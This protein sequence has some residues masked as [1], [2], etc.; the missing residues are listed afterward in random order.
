MGD[1]KL[2]I[3]LTL[4]A[5]LAVG[6]A[7]A[8]GAPFDDERPVDAIGEMLSIPETTGSVD[9]EPHRLPLEGVRPAE[10]VPPATARRPAPKPAR[11]APVAEAYPVDLLIALA[12]DAVYSDAPYPKGQHADPR[13]IKLQVLLDRAH[14]SPGVIDGINGGNVA[15]AIAAFEMMIGHPVDGVMDAEL[16]ARLESV[17]SEPVLVSYEL[18]EKDVA[19]P[20]TPVLPADYAEQA[21]L[22]AA[23]YRDPVEML[24]ERF[25]MDEGFLRRLNPDVD[26]TM[27][28]SVITVANPG[29]PQKAK[30]A[31]IV[32]DKGRR[33]IFAYDLA[34]RLVA[35]YPATIG[36]ADLPSPTGVHAVKAI[37]INPEYWYRPKVNF[38]QGENTKALRLPPGPNAPVGSVW[39]GLDKPTYGLHGTPEPSK[40]DKTN[41]HGCVRLTNWDANEL[42]HLVAPGVPVDFREPELPQTAET[43]P[44]TTGI[45]PAR[46]VPY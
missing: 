30:V 31:S 5:A 42:A 25:H 28:G 2:A 17:S 15:K 44:L 40:I 12:N 3:A 33:Q 11:P 10:P 24:A 16:W 13:M 6:E 26:F 1:G 21:Q 38:Q 19:G 34:G 39:I 37:A 43:E 27:A 7:A 20:F 18:T 29:S 9:A 35:S 46:A 14:A 22:P 32:A 23:G 36:S 45:T 4:A 8:Q 41:S